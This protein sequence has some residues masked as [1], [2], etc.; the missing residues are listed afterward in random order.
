[1]PLAQSIAVVT[2]GSS[3]IGAALAR[4]LAGRGWHCVLLAR[5]EER[6]RAVAAEVGGEYELCDVGDRE[7]VDRVAA[8]VIERHPAVKL[9]VNNAGFAGRGH[10]KRGRRSGRGFLDAEPERLE[11]LFRVNFLGAIWCLRAFIPALRAGRP[12]HVVNVASVAGAV[13]VPPG[14]YSAS[15]HALVAFSRA[16]SATLPSEGIH[17]HTVNPGLVETPGFPQRGTLGSR[18]LERAVVDP[19]YVA[20]RIVRAVE[21]DRRE[22]FVPGWYRVPALAQWIAPGVFSRLLAR[23]R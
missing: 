9:L 23:R 18:L 14:P 1:V 20:R 2:G 7:E 13:A 6:L 15:K 3:G 12:S 21:R 11:Q 8:R 19:E 17:V 5:N 22:I 16:L 10:G 4:E